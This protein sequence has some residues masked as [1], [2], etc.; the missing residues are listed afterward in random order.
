MQIQSKWVVPI[1]REKKFTNTNYAFYEHLRAHINF[2]G[3]YGKR[4][5]IHEFSITL[6]EEENPRM[7]SF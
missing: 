6:E 2:L 4:A 3:R 1:E 7:H 5:C